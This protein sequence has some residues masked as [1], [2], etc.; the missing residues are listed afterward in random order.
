MRKSFGTFFAVIAALAIV[1]SI[2]SCAH[3]FEKFAETPLTI[4]FIETTDIHGA[5]FPYDFIT[6]R[7]LDTSHTV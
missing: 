3:P 1:F 2:A 7:T 4:T 6:G 5:I